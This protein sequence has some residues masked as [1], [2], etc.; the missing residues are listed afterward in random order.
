MQL[1]YDQLNFALHIIRY[2]KKISQLTPLGEIITA[3]PSSVIDS[4]SHDNLLFQ[5]KIKVA[6][7]L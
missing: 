6:S 2:E 5:L 3:T 1:L 7:F 4:N